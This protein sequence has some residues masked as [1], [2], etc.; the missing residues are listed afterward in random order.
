[1]LLNTPTDDLCDGNSINDPSLMANFIEG[2]PD[3]P[4]P[5]LVNIQAK[6]VDISD[7]AIVNGQ[8]VAVAGPNGRETWLQY[9]RGNPIQRTRPVAN[10]LRGATPPN[11]VRNFAYK[12][13]LPPLQGQQ[14]TL[15]VRLLFRPLPPYFMRALS[16]GQQDSETSIAPL[17]TRVQTV[18]I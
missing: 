12:V 10:H 3:G 5:Q 9:L 4:D 6:L 13:A 16:A 17:L 8:P 14:T 7:V 15:K 11:G 1:G 18:E 2:C